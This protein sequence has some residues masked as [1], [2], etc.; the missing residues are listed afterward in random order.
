VGAAGPG[1]VVDGMVLGAE[2]APFIAA[3][4]CQSKSVDGEGGLEVVG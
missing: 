1:F 3:Q 4:S 2:P